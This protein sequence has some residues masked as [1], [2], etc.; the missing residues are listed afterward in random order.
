MF[1]SKSKFYKDGFVLHGKATPIQ[2]VHIFE[3]CLWDVY[4]HFELFV[5]VSD[6]ELLNKVAVFDV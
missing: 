3:H 2:M 1:V 4:E 6:L 5:R